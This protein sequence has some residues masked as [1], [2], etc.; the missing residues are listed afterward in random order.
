MASSK[1]SQLR[2]YSLPNEVFVHI[3]SP[4][5]TRDLLPLATIS[6]RFHD[7]VLRIIHYRL[8]LAAALKE[9]K[10]IL[11]CFHPSS[12]LTEP[13]VF[14]KYLGTDGLSDRYEGKGSL[15]EDV[16]TA[17]RLGRLTCLYSRFRPEV[18]IEQMGTGAR[19][20][21]YSDLEGEPGKENPAVTRP[22]NLED[23]EN[24][25]QLCVVA[26]VVKVVPGTDLLL[27]TIEVVDGVVRL[28]RDWLR[29]QGQRSSSDAPSNSTDDSILW[30]DTGQ[31]VGLKLRVRQKEVS[32]Q[33]FPI[34]I[35]RD[36]MPPANYEVDIE[37]LGDT[38]TSRARADAD[39]YPTAE[40]HIRT[41][42]LLLA[43]EQS[44]QDQRDYTRAVIFTRPRVE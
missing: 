35:H 13:H 25:S 15:Y 8:L 1:T 37:G 16:D 36:E 14:C 41:T 10:L 33:Q 31:N 23:F 5:S 27:S 18:T 17:K 32:Q 43:V 34:L 42:R 40:L 11:E 9:Y 20:T 30:V 6:H 26:S 29:D 24:F 12:K 21:P 19:I 3:L 39:T 2:L 7:L 28:F 22:V 4:F 38:A 44:Q